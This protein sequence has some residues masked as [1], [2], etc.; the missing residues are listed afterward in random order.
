MAI[1][2]VKTMRNSCVEVS[3]YGEKNYRLF[4]DIIKQE[5]DNLNY[6]DLTAIQ[7]FLLMNIGENIVT[8]GEVIS[9]GYYI[10]SNASYNVKKLIANG[11]ILQVPS[12]Y[13]K[14]AVYLKLTEKGRKLCGKID[15]SIKGHMNLFESRM[16]GKFDMNAGVEFLKNVE[17]V[18]KDLLQSRL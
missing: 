14:R 4:L 7:A 8:I 1:F 11:Y 10:G 15:E 9:R 5:L 6:T 18:W 2:Y 16:K 13:D 3:V 17:R 12:D